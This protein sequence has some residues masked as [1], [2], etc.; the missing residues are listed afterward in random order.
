MQ[1]A[2]APN[3]LGSSPL[4][5]SRLCRLTA[6]HR[7]LLN[8]SYQT[9]LCLVYAPKVICA[10][11][12]VLV[13]FCPSCIHWC[14]WSAAKAPCLLSKRAAIDAG[15]SR[16]ISPSHS[17]YCRPRCMIS[18]TALPGSRQSWRM[19]SRYACLHA[20]WGVSNIYLHIVREFAEPFCCSDHRVNLCRSGHA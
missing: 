7:A 13:R 5:A 17:C 2:P 16:A 1:P 9:D 11:C 19:L 8:D 12:I 10:G 14:I 18:K 4:Q 20:T 15:W 3:P 6:C